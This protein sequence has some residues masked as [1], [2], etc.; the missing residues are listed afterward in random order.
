MH[1]VVTRSTCRGQNARSA[2]VSH[3]F[4][5]FRCGFAWF[6]VAGARDCAPGQKA[7]KCEGFVEVAKSMANVGHLK[8][9]GKDMLVRDVW[10]SGR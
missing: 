9:I 1:V 10:R 8:K 3:H 5:R 4:G 7:A 6:C 2:P